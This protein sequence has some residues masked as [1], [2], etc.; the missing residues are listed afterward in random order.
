L[1]NILIELRHVY[2]DFVVRKG[3]VSKERR[4]GIWDINMNISEKE[5]VGMVG[6]SGGG[7]TVIAW[8]I[9]GLLKPTS[10]SIIYHPM[11]KDVVKM[12]KHE[13]KLYRRQ[14][15]IVFQDPYS[16]LDPTHTV[17]WHIERPLKLIKYKGDIDK[18]IEELLR[19]V[20]LDPK[21]VMNKYPFQLS[22]GQRQRVYL[23][24]ILAL[25]PRVIIA[26]E[27]VSNVD[28]SVRVVILDLFRYLRD[29]K[30]ISILYITHD[31]STLEYVADRVYVIKQGRIV[32]EG[33]TSDVIQNPKH[34]YT[35][36]LIQSVPNPYKRIE[37]T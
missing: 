6:G 35:K 17:K 27:P 24:R 15:Q 14:V 19:E 22:G 7:K 25:N 8:M 23:A 21:D 28:A 11:G 10:G 37:A 5:I 13:L 2:K 1:S 34:E 31:I 26:D 4:P 36:L 29:E 16:S 20:A 30:G 12:N 32:E 33:Y 9:V 3:I 18:K